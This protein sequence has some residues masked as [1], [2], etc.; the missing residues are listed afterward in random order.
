MKIHPKDIMA[1]IV[2][3]GY[4]IG[5]YLGLDGQLDGAFMLILGYYFVKR[6]SHEDSGN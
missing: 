1:L 4:Y 5:K 3:S 6:E 2:I